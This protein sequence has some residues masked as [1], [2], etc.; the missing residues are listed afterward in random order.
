MK[1]KWLYFILIVSNLG[2]I[3]ILHFLG[4]I[5]FSEINILQFDAL[6]YQKIAT[7]GYIEDYLFAFFPLFPLVWGIL[8]FGPISIAILNSIVYF[9]GIILLFEKLKLKANTASIFLVSMPFNIFYFIPYTESFF[10]FASVLVIIGIKN[11][12]DFVLYTGLLI[13]GLIRPSITLF[14]PTIILY[15]S[16]TCRNTSIFKKLIFPLLFS[17]IGLLITN[18]YQFLFSNEW[19]SFYNAQSLWDNKIRWPNLPFKSWGGDF[20]TLIDAFAFFVGLSFFIFLS[21]LFYK[22]HFLKQSLK[23]KNHELFSL[24]F[25]VGSFAIIIIYRGGVLFS[26][27]RFIFSTAFFIPAFLFISSYIKTLLILNAKKYF[28]FYFIFSLIIWL[29]FFNAFRHIQVVFS[30]LALSTF[31]LF[32]IFSLLNEDKNYINKLVPYSLLIFF[33]LLLQLT[34]YFRYFNGLWIA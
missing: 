14:L 5:E 26:L 4:Y 21:I 11:K 15:Y 20:I 31:I 1:L 30:F 18:Y 9:F 13:A 34:F 7:N 3:I 10:F 28:I 32:Y 29:I 23:I 12:N 22:K 24:I 6:L 2:S 8:N 17:L 16:L 19:F 27:N 33:N 25:A